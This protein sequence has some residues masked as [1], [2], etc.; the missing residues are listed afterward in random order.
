MALSL[1]TFITGTRDFE[2]KQ[3][4]VLQ[5]LKTRRAELQ[6]NKLYPT[7]VEVIDLLR[8][9]EDFLQNKKDI[10]S[11]LPGRLKEIDLENKKLVYESLQGSDEDL[12]R[13]SDLIAWAIPHLQALRDEAMEIFNFV[14][15]HISIEHVGIVPMYREEGYWF[16]PENAASLLHLLKYEVSLF[17]SA[18]ERY[19]TL[20]TRLLESLE[21]AAIA[22]SPESIKMNLIQKYHDLPNP[23]TYACETDL[24]FPYAETILP[25][26]KRKLM[27]RVFS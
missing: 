14:D 2:A 4:Q 24:E 25:V 9:L 23:A 3:Y 20:K 5:E 17:T 13:A 18:T 10:E 15:E 8:V 1:E 7:L 11:R 22:Y 26:A 27:S 6:H 21:Q 16:V 19:R 12:A